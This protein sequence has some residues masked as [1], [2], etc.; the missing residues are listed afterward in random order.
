M[1]RGLIGT[2]MVAAAAAAAML[3]AAQPSP[4]APAAKLP[5]IKHVFTIV[6]ENKDYDV[7]FGENPP[8]PYLAEK[9]PAKGQLLT[10][11]YGTGHFSLGNYITMISGQSENPDTQGDCMTRFQDV[12]PGT[13]GADGQ[14]LGSG[15]VYPPA[16]KTV[17]GQLQDAGFTWRGYMEDMGDDV[18]RD[19]AKTCAHPRVGAT[20]LTQHAEPQD[21]YATRHNPFMYFHSIIDDDINCAANVVNLDRLRRDLAKQRRTRNFSFISPDLCSDGHDEECVNPEQAGGYPGINAFLRQWVPKIL[22][23]RAFKRDGLLIVTFDEA[24]FLFQPEQ[25]TACCFVPTGPNTPQQGISGPGG[26]L[27]GTVL[28]SPFIKRGTVNDEPYNHY[29]YLHT[30]EDIF[31]LGYLGYAGRDAVRSFG[32]DVFGK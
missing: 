19:G 11:Y 32:A 20:D 22:K 25:A 16:V 4:A 8:A 3:G 17:A 10:Q 21:Q 23:S 30:I 13:I 28:V 2:A 12:V 24:E 27:T 6:L 15:C 5:A 1:R 18:N 14:A 26:G 9:L 29:D 31:G 7:T